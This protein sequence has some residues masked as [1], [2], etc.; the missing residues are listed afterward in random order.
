MPKKCVRRA[1]TALGLHPHCSALTQKI[2]LGDEWAEEWTRTE[3]PRASPQY[4]FQKAICREGL[5]TP[6]EMT[7]GGTGI[8]GLGVPSAAPGRGRGAKEP[9]LSLES[10][11]NI[12]KTATRAAKVNSVPGSSKVSEFKCFP[13]A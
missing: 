7:P 1:Q 13:S 11:F 10:V 2:E 8:P 6:T 4:R 5:G 9:R 3:S 12:C